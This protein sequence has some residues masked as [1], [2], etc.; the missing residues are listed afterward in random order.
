MME[1]KDIMIKSFQHRAAG[2]NDPRIYRNITKLKTARDLSKIILCN[3]HQS[4]IIQ[5]NTPCGAQYLN[6]SNRAIL[7]GMLK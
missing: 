2:E 3:P 6:L 4:N 5:T 7:A 1:V